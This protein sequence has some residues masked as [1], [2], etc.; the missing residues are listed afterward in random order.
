MVLRFL[1]TIIIGHISSSYKR[2][3]GLALNW[4]VI[5]HD[6]WRE[7]AAEP[8][9]L[10]TEAQQTTDISKLDKTEAAVKEDNGDAAATQGV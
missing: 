2:L 10:P 5:V 9:K 3:D 8:N 1:S 4:A 6:A 7:D